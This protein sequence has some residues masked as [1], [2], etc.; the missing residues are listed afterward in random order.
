M[1]ITSKEIATTWKGTTGMKMSLVVLA[2]A[3]TPSPLKQKF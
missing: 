2:I 3:A 1:E